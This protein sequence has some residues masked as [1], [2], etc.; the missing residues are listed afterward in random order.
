[1]TYDAGQ[2]ARET[3]VM[4]DPLPGITPETISGSASQNEGED[5]PLIQSSPIL[6]ASDSVSV[7]ITQ[8]TEEP[9]QMTEDG[10][11]RGDGLSVL[12]KIL[13]GKLLGYFLK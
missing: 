2:N 11:L 3:D 10:T 5:G 4:N 6:K 8:T 12:Q 7:G 1:L 13:L 9:P